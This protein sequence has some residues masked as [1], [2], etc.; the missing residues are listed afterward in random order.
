MKE[1]HCID[2]KKLETQEVLMN[3]Q[4]KCVSFLQNRMDASEDAIV[5]A[6][7]TFELTEG[8]FLNDD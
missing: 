2:C 1:M 6:A 8:Y 7:E 5:F 4:N 3:I